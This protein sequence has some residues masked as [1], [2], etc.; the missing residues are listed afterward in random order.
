MDYG[1]LKKESVTL[2]A[3]AVIPFLESPIINN[4]SYIHIYGLVQITQ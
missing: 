4:E 1:F 3:L 2:S